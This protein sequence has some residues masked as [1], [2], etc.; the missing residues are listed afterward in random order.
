MPS[1]SF[2]V[3]ELVKIK[4][5]IHYEER[6]LC[7]ILLLARPEQRLVYLTSLPVD[8]AIIDYYLRFLAHPDDARRRL[9]LVAVHEPGSR[10]LTAKLLD[11]PE[12]LEQVGALLSDDG[13]DDGNTAR[14]GT[15]GNDGNAALVPFNVTAGEWRVADALGIPL[16]GPPSHLAVL[17]SK[18]GARR[19]ARRAEV[20][21]AE[22]EEAL[23]SLDE[24]LGA[25]ERL[26]AR[27]PGARAAV[28]KLNHGF[29]GQGNALVDLARRH[30]TLA[31]TPTTFC[32]AG[33]SW[34]SFSSKIAADG[35]IVEEVL[36]ATASP[37]VQ[38]R[39]AADASVQ[40]VS[41]HDQVLGGPGG[42]VYLGCRFPAD[43]RY[44]SAITDAAVR[45]GQVLA[46][47]GV[48]GP[49]GIDFLITPGSDGDDVTLSEINLR[50]GGTTHPFWMA[51]LLTGGTYDV[52]SGELRCG[53]R[54]KC[55]V[56]TDNLG[57]TTPAGCSPAWA[58]TAVERAGLAYDRRTGTGTALHLLGALP[59]FSKVGVTSIGDSPE[60]AD[61]RFDEVTAVLTGHEGCA[62]PAT[63]GAG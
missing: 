52:A 61:A 54:P 3:A 30:R 19:V 12:V 37:S 51:R 11:H 46:A 13:S 26:R 1:L 58:V 15:D 5:V 24:V 32:A 23:F 43:R 38:L 42:Q 2:P 35:A 17:G 14:N 6:L 29:S 63:R 20:A 16:D 25:V 41:T 40:V 31:E 18:T 10:P 56:A 60:E 33:E 28:V 34:S 22:G 44:R 39:I 55:Y 8:P 49:F 47:E 59:G 50:M 45:V 36:P 27:Q 57:A 62:D 9:H 4:G 21:V 53:E 7:T 48:I